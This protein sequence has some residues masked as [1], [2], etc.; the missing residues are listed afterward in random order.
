LLSIPLTLAY[1]IICSLR[2]L[3]DVPTERNANWIFQSTVDRRKHDSR[4]VGLKVML[5]M[6]LP[7]LVLIA[8]PLYAKKWGWAVAVLH[9]TYV[10]LSTAALGE[11]L[12]AGFRKIPFTCLHVMSKDRVLV[13][14]IFFLLGYSVFSTTNSLLELSFLNR[15]FRMVLLP[16]LF[17][18]LC[19]AVRAAER[20]LPVSERDLIFEDR[21]RPSIQVLDLTH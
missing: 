19:L 6:I 13:M 18:A 5:T 8:L 9:T 21:P 17:V 7:W 2:V 15:P 14:V 10:T 3:Y 12:L 4:T 20:D 16:L 11:L 1:F